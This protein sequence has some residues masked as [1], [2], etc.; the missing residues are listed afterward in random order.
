MQ[1]STINYYAGTAS[2]SLNHKLTLGI[3]SGQF[4]ADFGRALSS[5]CCSACMYTHFHDYNNNNYY[6]G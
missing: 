3:K 4:G 6:A 1:L 2:D 5:L